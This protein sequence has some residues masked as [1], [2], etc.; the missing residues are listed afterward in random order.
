VTFTTL[1]RGDIYHSSGN[2]L[3]TNTLY[4]GLPGWQARDR[5][6]GDRHEVG[7]GRHAVRRHPGT[8]PACP[9]RR[10]AA[11]PQPCHSQRGLALDQLE[12]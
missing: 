2:S 6:G 3:T 4:Q 8:D 10:H 12:D 9:D 11:Y 7:F 5:D 1:L